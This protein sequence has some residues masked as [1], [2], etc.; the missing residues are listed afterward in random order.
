VLSYRG[1]PPYRETRQYVIRVLRRYDREAARAAAI[2]IYGASSTPTRP[3]R[4]LLKTQLMSYPGASPYPGASYPGASYPGAS[5][6]GASYPGAPYQ[7]ETSELPLAP[8]E[9][10]K[11]MYGK[12]SP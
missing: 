2:R 10:P 4:P 11:V 5:Y 7:G 6:P 3:E 9:P 8:V 12:E 1:V